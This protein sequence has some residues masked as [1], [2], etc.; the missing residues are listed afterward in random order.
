MPRSDG[1]SRKNDGDADPSRTD[2][3]FLENL[4]TAYWQSEVLFSALDLKLFDHIE[5]GS[6]TASKLSALSGCR[7]DGLYRLL[8]VLKRM[9]LVGES[10]GNWFNSQVARHYLV[11]KSPSY[12]GDFFLYRRAMQE[13]FR[14]LTRKISLND[15]SETG[16]NSS[17]HLEVMADAVPD[18]VDNYAERN[19]H[20]VRALDQLARHKSDETLKTLDDPEMVKKDIE[21]EINKEKYFERP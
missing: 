3:Q 17:G 12:M 13:N 20:Y 16:R 9:E 7:E 5:S 14:L 18:S 4:S 15:A 11:V 1:P 21:K 2:Y 8:R 19:F 6:M 10:D